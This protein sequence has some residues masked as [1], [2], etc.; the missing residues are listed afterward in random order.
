MS[1]PSKA[2]GACGPEGVGVSVLQ[3]TSDTGAHGRLG[4]LL[5]TQHPPDLFLYSMSKPV[6]ML[7]P[8]NL[9]V[10]RR[11]MLRA[12]TSRI[13]SSGGS[14]G[15]GTQQGNENSIRHLGLLLSPGVDVT[16][17]LTKELGAL[18]LGH[19]WG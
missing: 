12:F 1:L 10:Q 19:L 3:G 14:G 5:L 17:G 11:F 2:M 9:W 16:S 15:S 7:F 13:S 18:G 6:M 4:S 8:S